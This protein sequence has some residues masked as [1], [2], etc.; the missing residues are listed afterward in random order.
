MSRAPMVAGITVL[1]VDDESVNRQVARR[2]LQKLGCTVHVLSVS[3]SG[4]GWYRVALPGPLHDHHN[5]RFNAVVIFVSHNL[6]L[7]ST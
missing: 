7:N 3:P 6:N 2:M 5:N 4:S 1:F